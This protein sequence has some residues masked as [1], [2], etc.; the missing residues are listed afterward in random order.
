MSCYFALIFTMQYLQKWLE[1]KEH[2]KNGFFIVMFWSVKSKSI[3]CPM[4]CVTCFS[5]TIASF[6]W[7]EWVRQKWDVSRP[8]TALLT[9]TDDVWKGLK[10]TK[11]VSRTQVLYRAVGTLDAG[12]IDTGYFFHTCLIQCLIFLGIL[13]C[14]ESKIWAFFKGLRSFRGP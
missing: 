6:L 4:D 12:S 10:K 9:V 7:G 11:K 8:I 13:Y 2:D 3:C 14:P 5:L 1:Q